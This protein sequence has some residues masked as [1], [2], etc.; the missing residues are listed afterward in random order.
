MLT[1][2]QATLKEKFGYNDFKTDVQ[3]QATMA[4]YDGKN[5][6]YICL[7][8]GSGKSLCFQLPAILKEN[9]VAIVFSPLIA[10]IK[11]QIDF[12]RSKKINAQTLNSRI[13]GKDREKIINNLQSK[14][15]TI[16]LLYIT[17]E[18]SVQ[19]YFKILI[20]QMYK[21]NKISYLVIDEAHCL[22]L[23]G[24]DFRPNYRELGN[25]RQICPTVPILALTATASK[26][27]ERN[28]GI[29][30]CRKKEA[31]ETIANKLT[32]AGIP[33]LAYHGS[34]KSSDRMRVQDKWTSGEV[35]VIAATCSFGMGVDKGPVRFVVHWTIPQTIAGYYQESGRAGRDGKPAFCRIYVSNEEYSA[36]S[37]LLKDIATGD[38]VDQKKRKWKDF[39][40]MIEYCMQTKCRHAVFSKYF[41]D[42]P[43]NCKDKCDVC[44]NK[45][46]VQAR[47]S[48]FETYPTKPRR[49][50]N[51]SDG[52]ALP[53]CDNGCD[54]DE[55]G[56]R[57]ISKE[58]L[59]AREKREAKEFL[60]RHFGMRRGN[61]NREEIEKKNKEAAK[62]AEVYAADSTDRKVKGL[63]VQVREHMFKQLRTA[64]L[65]NHSKFSHECNV[66]LKEVDVHVLACRLE[67]KIL[68]DT[69]VANKYKYNAFQLVSA[70]QR[71]TKNNTIYENLQEYNPNQKGL[72]ITN[73][74]K[75]IEARNDDS[76]TTDKLIT[77]SQSSNDSS[78]T[79]KFICGF[80]T[81]LELSNNDK[82]DLKTSNNKEISQINNLSDSDN[83]SKMP[84]KSTSIEH[85]EECDKT[86]KTWNN[87]IEVKE[88]E[89]NIVAD[90]MS[91]YKSRKN[92]NHSSTKMF[93]EKKIFKGNVNSDE[94]TKK[95]DDHSITKEDCL[96]TEGDIDCVFIKETSAVKRGSVDVKKKNLPITTFT[97]AT[98]LLDDK[99]EILH[100]TIDHTSAK[101]KVENRLGKWITRDSHKNRSSSS[102]ISSKSKSIHEKKVTSATVKSLESKSN[103]VS[104]KTESGE[105]QITKKPSHDGPNQTITISDSDDCSPESIEIKKSFSNSK[106]RKVPDFSDIDTKLQP[107]SK[108]VSLPDPHVRKECVMKLREEATTSNTYS[109][110]RKDEHKNKKK[111]VESTVISTIEILKNHLKKYYGSKRIP[112]RES[113]REISKE[114]HKRILNKRIYDDAGIKNFV[115]NFL[116]VK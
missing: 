103:K 87:S 52:F 89:V 43:P 46:L 41:G 22:S 92:K 16:K 30:Y 90:L 64:L 86:S 42:S 67:Y 72:S 56:G 68:C 35:P 1:L 94:V 58:Q 29:I 26:E 110:Q 49:P 113:F 3:K 10:L 109:A 4:V 15:P 111:S 24:H 107:A 75:N 98:K 80:K 106:K 8:T 78:K 57:R 85:N 21:N 31:T 115:K 62:N 39:E 2:L 19:R 34:L 65:E 104:G 11:N 45:D 91:K 32:K 50:I 102:H 83:F 51:D 44:E 114:I 5:D 27:N 63:T 33:T 55:S 9:Q 23:W 101:K 40:K 60:E 36:I 96:G 14:A 88:N 37:Y 70:V 97:T 108:R 25:F 66:P 77:I 116:E 59:L 69:R 17:P 6:V 76:K 61:N 84:S 79:D 53:K 73:V 81:A 71:C 99:S 28:C 100:K 20:E 12:L 47:I 48:E 38:Q 13:L 74:L 93:A 112:D 54:D 18:M 7:P 95:K 82:Q 105:N